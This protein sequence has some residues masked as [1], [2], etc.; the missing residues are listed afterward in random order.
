MLARV[1]ATLRGRQALGAATG[2]LAVEDGEDAS[3]VLDEN[4][5]VLSFLLA[6]LFL[7]YNGA[8]YVLLR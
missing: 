1:A 2:G 3:V 5:L 7:F 4:C 8:D 6:W